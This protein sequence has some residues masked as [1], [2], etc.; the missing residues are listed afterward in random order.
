[1]AT[2]LKGKCATGLGVGPT[3]IYTAPALTTTL[4]I[5]LSLSNINAGTITAGARMTD[6]S[7]AATAYIG[8]KAF[9]L[10]AGA[11]E[12]VVSKDA[13]LILETGD[14]ISI[15]GNTAASIDYTL[16]YVEMT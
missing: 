6:T 13:P 1:M 14:S 16:S 9:S 4:V 11:A 15:D 3:T 2:T 8:G 7:A 5:G 10:P 12:W